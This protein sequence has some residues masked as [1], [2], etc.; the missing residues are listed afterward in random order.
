MPEII[1]IDDVI[2]NEAIPVS[3]R[4]VAPFLEE[5]QAIL[6]N[7]IDSHR[8]KKILVCINN[9]TSPHTQMFLKIKFKK[10]IY[11]YFYFI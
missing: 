5:A 11:I 1:T 2:V 7:P 10:N 3:L 4:P 9:S 6:R 8:L